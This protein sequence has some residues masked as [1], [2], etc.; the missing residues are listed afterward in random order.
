MFAEIHFVMQKN[1][2]GQEDLVG[3]LLCQYFPEAKRPILFRIDGD[4]QRFFEMLEGEQKSAQERKKKQKLPLQNENESANG[5]SKFILPGSIA[6]V[7]VAPKSFSKTLTAIASSTLVRE[8]LEKNRFSLF[9]HVPVRENPSSF[10]DQKSIY[11][12]AETLISELATVVWY[13]PN[14]EHLDPKTFDSIPE[15]KRPF[16]YGE[17]TLPEISAEARTV[18]MSGMQDPALRL[19]D[20][21]LENAYSISATVGAHQWQR[22]MGSQLK[23]VFQ[24]TP[25]LEPFSIPLLES[26]PPS[27]EGVGDIPAVLAPYLDDPGLRSAA[28]I[29][30]TYCKRLEALLDEQRSLLR[31]NPFEKQSYQRNFD[32]FQ[33]CVLGR[34]QAFEKDVANEGMVVRE[35][36]KR[37][38]QELI[39]WAWATCASGV[40]CVIGMLTLFMIS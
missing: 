12:I 26:L 16:L 34:L 25:Q 11:L 5:E 33:E 1:S 10:E 35:T 3:W 29:A 30:H 20:I 13:H 27:F 17:I 37:H 31:V 8:G 9:F 15:E 7:V 28:V 14:A 23:K 21:R 2:G 18:S 38:S 24:I 4:E 36:M 40:I 39:T 6:V 32:E 22:F 19:S